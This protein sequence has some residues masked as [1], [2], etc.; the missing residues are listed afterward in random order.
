MT[1]K[2]L[3]TDCPTCG[4]TGKLDV[5]ESLGVK[6]HR[7]GIEK[8]AAEVE[9]ARVCGSAASDESERK[10]IIAARDMACEEYHIWRDL[11]EEKG[12]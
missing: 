2:T 4:G 7:L 1:S 10:A 9:C 12:E 8:Y 5:R 3:Q 11:Y 6:V